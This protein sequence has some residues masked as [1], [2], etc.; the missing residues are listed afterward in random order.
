MLLF[1]DTKLF[2]SEIP[3]LLRYTSYKI[4]YPEEYFASI[5]IKSEAL[6]PALLSI[7]LLFKHT[8]IFYKKKY[9]N[10]PI[11]IIITLFYEK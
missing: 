3:L 2:I 1:N 10:W 7:L 5:D 4:N 8:N 6:R 11:F 9:L